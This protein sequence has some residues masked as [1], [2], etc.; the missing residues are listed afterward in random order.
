MTKLKKFF[1]P[2]SYEL[3]PPT[4]AGP[5]EMDIDLNVKVFL[6]SNF[7]CVLNVVCF[8]LGDSPASEFRRRVITQKKVYNMS[9]FCLTSMF[10][11]THQPRQ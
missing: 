9:K 10:P 2:K 1:H 11:K 8:L 3:Q 7:R 4:A 6:I 5:S